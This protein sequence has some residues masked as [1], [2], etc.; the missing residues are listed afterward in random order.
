MHFLRRAQYVSVHWTLLWEMRSY[1]QFLFALSKFDGFLDLEMTLSKS[2]KTD[3]KNLEVI[4][5][6]MHLFRGD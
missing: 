6:G 5:N 2:S 1:S 4:A 3:T